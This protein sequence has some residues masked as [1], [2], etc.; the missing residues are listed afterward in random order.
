MKP[1]SILTLIIAVLLPLSFSE[2]GAKDIIIKADQFSDSHNE[3]LSPLLAC[4]D[5][6]LYGLD[7]NGDWVEYTF[8]MSEFGTHDTGLYVRGTLNVAF[9]LQMTLT[10]MDVIDVQTFDF[11]FTGGGFS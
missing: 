3:G 11:N 4:G 5:G 9:H 8:S 7:C 6:C 10:A 1:V 2:A